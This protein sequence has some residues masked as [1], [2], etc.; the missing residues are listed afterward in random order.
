METCR[1]IASSAD[2]ID[3]EYIKWID[4]RYPNRRQH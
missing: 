4:K 1:R 2:W 3:T